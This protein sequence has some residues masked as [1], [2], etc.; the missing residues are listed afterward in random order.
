M[1][2]FQAR[3]VGVEFDGEANVDSRPNLDYVPPEY[4][5]KP[6]PQSDLFALGVLTYA[7]FNHGETVFASG[8]NLQA[9]RYNLTKVTTTSDRNESRL[10]LF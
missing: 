5:K 3:W 9:H 2:W 1:T 8:G 6:V 7:V 4:E 10:I